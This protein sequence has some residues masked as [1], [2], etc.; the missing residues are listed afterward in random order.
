[1]TDRTIAL[2]KAAFERWRDGTVEFVSLRRSAR[3]AFFEV[4]TP[5]GVPTAS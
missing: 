1:M 2:A 3:T 4:T 5:D